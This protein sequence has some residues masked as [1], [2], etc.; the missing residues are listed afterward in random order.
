MKFTTQLYYVKPGEP[1]DLPA[2]TQRPQRR[3]SKRSKQGRVLAL[4]KHVDRRDYDYFRNLKSQY[5]NF[6][7][8]N[9]NHLADFAEKSL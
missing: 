1:E 8:N 2:C 3:P 6:W 7:N 4:V 5:L 9:N